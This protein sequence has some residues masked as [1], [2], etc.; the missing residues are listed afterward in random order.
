MQ[1]LLLVFLLACGAAS[2]GQYVDE[3][4]NLGNMTELARVSAFSI[5]DE[6]QILPSWSVG[7]VT[8]TVHGQQGYG[9]CSGHGCGGRVPFY[10]T[11]FAQPT[12]H[13]AVESNDGGP[14]TSVSRATDTSGQPVS[15]VCTSS[16]KSPC[17]EWQY[18]GDLPASAYMLNLAGTSCGGYQ[19]QIA[20]DSYVYVSTH[21]AP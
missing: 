16:Q 9:V 10:R 20:G 2:A 18:T 13:T 6:F 15:F 8:I 4:S 12:L 3:S 21:F 11:T 19:C 14:W 17:L 5:V 1:Y 7:S